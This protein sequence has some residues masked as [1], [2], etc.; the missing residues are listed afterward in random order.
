MQLKVNSKYRPENVKRIR[1]NLFY[2]EE[3]ELNFKLKSFLIKKK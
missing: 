3:K 1:K 2:L